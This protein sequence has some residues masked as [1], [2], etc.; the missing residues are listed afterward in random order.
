MLEELF[1]NLKEKRPL[2]YNVTNSVTIND[3]ANAIVALGARAIMSS[4]ILEAKD[5]I[6]NSKAVNINIGTVNKKSFKL[7]STA[8]KLANKYKKA[9]ILDV[10]GL[11]ASS[12]RGA[13]VQKLIKN[14]KFTVIKGNA[15]EIKA[16]VSGKKSVSYKN[17]LG[18][19]A[20]TDDEITN[21]SDLVKPSIKD[22]LIDVKNT[23]KNLNS[24]IVITGPIDLVVSKKNIIVIENGSKMMGE[25][26]GTGCILGAVLA[27][28]IGA[29][30]TEDDNKRENVE[31]SCVTA[32]CMYGVCGELAASTIKKTDGVIVFKNKLLDYLSTIKA[33][34]IKKHAKYKII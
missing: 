1:K 5:L 8:G 7:M 10:V 13:V 20:I 3:C 18:V 32:L 19:D 6:K 33:E 15:T 2:V 28:F 22:F 31:N 24:V 9:V 12:Y 27:S 11:G 29:N 30:A 23:A 17:N 4:E 14:I 25:V 26:C 21:P 16:L 34:D